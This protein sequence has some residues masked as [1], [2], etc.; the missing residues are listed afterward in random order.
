MDL[1]GCGCMGFSFTHKYKKAIISFF[2]FITELGDIGIVSYQDLQTMIANKGVSDESEIRMIIPFLVKAQVISE[3]NCIKTSTGTRIRQLVIDN[4]FF[5]EQGIEFIKILKMEINKDISLDKEIIL[6]IEKLYHK[7]GMVLFL[8]LCKSD[9]YIY[10]ELFFFLKKYKSIDKNEFYILTNSIEK[11]K[12]NKLEEI[13]LKYR[14][15]TIGEL[16]ITR[17]VND[18]QYLIGTLQ[19][20]GII[21]EN[22]NKRFILTNDADEL[23][24]ENNE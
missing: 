14:N 20:F 24:V 10:R 18:W 6:R 8:S 13:I 12:K 2:E 11:S 22:E 23:E 19:Q 16:K 21:E 9:D 7:A 4:N 15:G 5:T 17:N 1:V 3:K